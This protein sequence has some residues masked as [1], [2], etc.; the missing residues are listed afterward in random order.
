M[1]DID[2]L[3]GTL[4]N[5]ETIMVTSKGKWQDTYKSNNLCN[6]LKPTLIFNS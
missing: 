2:L 3:V 1:N 5:T 4:I 6:F